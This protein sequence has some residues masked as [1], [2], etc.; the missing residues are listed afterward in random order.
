MFKKKRHNKKEKKNPQ[1]EIFY[2]KRKHTH[3][4]FLN[5]YLVPN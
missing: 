1:I 3:I 2:K 4:P 5:P